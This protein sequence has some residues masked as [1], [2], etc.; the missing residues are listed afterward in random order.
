M[1]DRPHFSYPFRFDNRGAAEVE[2]GSD[3]EIVAAVQVIIRT[4]VGW[5]SEDPAFGAPDMLFDQGGKLLPSWRAD[6]EEFEPRI[7][8]LASI[9]VDDLDAAVSH[10]ALRLREGRS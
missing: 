9:S 8:A 4:P 1:P 3:A 5:R 10:V 7:V 2:Q 6:I